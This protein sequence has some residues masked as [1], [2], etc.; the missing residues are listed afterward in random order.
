MAL[1]PDVQLPSNDELTVPQEITLS[2]PWFKAVVPYM[3]KHCEKTINEFML[4]RKELEDPR[5]VLKEG[6]DVTACG[7]QF[8]Q[9]LKKSCASETDALGHCIDHGSAKLYVSRCRNEQKAMDK[10]VL[11]N[12]KIERP[13]LGYWNSPHVHESQA[14]APVPINRD[15]KA[16][17]AKVLHELPVEYHLRKDY[18]KY[19]DWKTN[20]WES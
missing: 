1:T 15:Y 10:C 8:L 6:R 4:R 18:R 19:N 5:A 13:L 12:L 11:D 3:A 17:A 9:A 16:E 7:I 2:T 14:P 20:L